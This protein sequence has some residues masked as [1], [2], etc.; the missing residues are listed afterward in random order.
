MVY[1]VLGLMSGSSLDGLD[2]AFVQLEETGGKWAYEIL[3]ADCYPYEKEWREKLQ[4]AATLSAKD[5][6]LLHTEYGHYTGE[7]INAFINKNHLHYQVAFIA[8]HG[9]TTFHLPEQQMTAQVGDGAAIAAV[10]GLPVISDLR[11]LDV[12]LGGQGAPIVPIGEKY[13]FPEYD[14]LLNIGGIANLSFNDQGNYIAFDVCPANRVLN[15]LAKILGKEYDVDGLLA[16][17]GMIQED[18]LQQLNSLDYYSRPYPKSL[19]NEF[20]T[21]TVLPLINAHPVS[22]QSK[23]RTYAEHVALQVDSAIKKLLSAASGASVPATAGHRLLV[24]G[25]GAFNRFLI[26]RIR[27]TLAVPGIETVIPEDN[28]VQYKEALIMAFI[29]TLRWRLENTTLA[30]AT[31][32][33][34]DS[35]GG[36][37]WMGHDY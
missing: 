31:G 28:V 23:L 19:A 12:A 33:T 22:I 7:K 13:L 15:E 8:S 26:K 36:A 17:S 21:E 18:M 27:E 11:A 1:K 6:L 4:A 16:S 34:R 20:G 35:I 10:T 32:A 5:Y 3:V 37:L 24:T 14:L 30:S 29:G 25:G 9:H 2:L